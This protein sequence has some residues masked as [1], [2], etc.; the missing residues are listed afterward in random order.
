MSYKVR[1]VFQCKP[2]KARELVEK[3]KKSFASMQDLDGFRNPQIM[4]DAVASYWTVVIESE[5][6]SLERFEKQQNEYS[7][8]PA[9]REAMAGYMDLVEGGRREIWRIV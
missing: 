6:D 2:G 5:V 7:T 8:R 9:A 1:E 4:V 3:F